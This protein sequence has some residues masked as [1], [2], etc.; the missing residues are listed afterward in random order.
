[1]GKRF[2][3]L[4]PYLILLTILAITFF[5]ISRRYG[6]ND[7]PLAISGTIEAVEV[8]VAFE[9]GG[10]I[11]QVL[12]KEGEVV[13]TGDVIALL[14]GEI[15]QT[16]YESA[17]ASLELAQA[18]MA[19]V[20]VQPME[21]QR[22]V[23]ISQAQL[24]YIR[25]RQT[26]QD[27]IENA[28]L[29]RAEAEQALE[30]A[31][32]VLE[33]QLKSDIQRSLALEAIAQGEKELDQAKRNLAILT[34][35]PPQTAVDQAYAN[36]LLAGDL[37]DQTIEDIETAKRKLKSGLG[38]FY[39]QVLNEE[40]K[41]QLRVAIRN[42]EIK[43]SRD[44]LAYENSVEK[45]N[46]LLN[47]P[48]PVELA[49][50]EAA[51]GMAEAQLGQK[52]REYERVKNGPSQ[53]DIAVLE[54]RVRSARRVYEALQDGPDPDDLAIA[55][56][57][58]ANAA[59]KLSLAKSD[60][61]QEQLAGAQAQVD[62]ARAA[63]NA[64]QVQLNK[65]VLTAPVE[66]VV[67]HRSIEPGEVVDPGTNAI[68]IGLLDELHLTVYL[69]GG[70]YDSIRQ[71]E[72]VIIT[73]DAYPDETFSGKIIAIADKSGLVPRNIE[74]VEGGRDLIFPVTIVLEKTRLL[75]PGM[76]AKIAFSDL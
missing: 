75:K 13:Q 14:E 45:Y 42:L 36:M 51:L 30:D 70:Y 40:Y 48:D 57:N 49:L 29:V 60:T 22:Q 9:I 66:G 50:A 5:L 12:V 6:S 20:A 25:A 23:A 15:L 32:E 34:N 37:K 19:F 63:L 26:L 35:P 33:D 3:K 16:Q 74:R 7:H 27:L 53:A 47:P 44:Q 54:A 39:P 17:L 8:A 61:I 76:L 71:S 31:D 64:I 11:D 59:A 46:Q 18:N 38:P 55:Q 52:R 58:V 4:I 69:P 62:S 24:E 10:Q 68:T 2:K 1:M 56:A 72:Q 65:L 73:S 21:E 67:L 43:R 41:K 28:E